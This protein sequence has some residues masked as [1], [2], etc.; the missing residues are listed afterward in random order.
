MRW[1]S[2]L[3][4]GVSL[5]FGAV[6][7]NKANKTELMTLNGVG[8]AKA[9]AILE[10]RKKHNCFSKVDEIKEVKG[11]GDKFLQKNRINMTV[12]SCKK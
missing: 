12:S 4:L 10:Y 6:D 1:L 7:I 11:L 8:E 2:L 5:S 3:I 9:N